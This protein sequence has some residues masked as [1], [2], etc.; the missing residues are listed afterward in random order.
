MTLI[1]FIMD[2]VAAAR[3]REMRVIQVSEPKIIDYIKGEAPVTTKTKSV[4]SYISKDK[5]AVQQLKNREDYVLASFAGGQI[6]T[7][8]ASQ[9]I[10]KG[11][12]NE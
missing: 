8:V 3:N 7:P 12:R 2:S 10:S 6:N 11:G 1:E 4:G 5:T 9:L